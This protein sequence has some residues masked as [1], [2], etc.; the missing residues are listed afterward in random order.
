MSTTTSSLKPLEKCNF[1]DLFISNLPG[2]TPEDTSH[3]PSHLA[4]TS[5][6]VP[7]AC[8]SS[9][10]P[11]LVKAPKLLGWSEDMAHILGIEKPE[12]DSSSL[13]ALAGNSILPGMNPY[14]ARYGGHQFGHWAGQLGDGRAI[15]LGE[16]IIPE[17]GRWE[18]Q[19]KGAGP[20]PYSRRSDGRAVLRSSLREFLCSE[21]MHFLGIPTTRALSLVSTGDNVIRDMFYDGNPRPE[22]GAI[23]CRVSPSFIRFGNFEIHAHSNEHSILTKLA[24]F[25]IKEYFPDLLPHSKL[26]SPKLISL[27]KEL[28]KEIYAEWFKDVC[29]KTALMISHWMRVGFVHGVMNTDNMSILGLT[30]DYGPYGW[31]E[32]YDH[33][34]T[35]NTTDAQ[36]KR[37]AFANQVQIGLWNLARFGEALL[38]LVEEV[39]LLESGLKAYTETFKES[40]QSMLAKKL[41]LSN[42]SHEDDDLLISDLYELLHETETDMTLF[43][44]NLGGLIPFPKDK[45]NSTFQTNLECLEEAFYEKDILNSDYRAKL[46]AWLSRY[47]TRSKND[48]LSPEDKLITMNSANPHFILRNYLSHQASELAAEGDLSLLNRLLEALKRPYDPLPEHRDLLIRRPEWARNKAGCS[49]LSCSS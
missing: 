49:A 15:T 5:R 7:K 47:I 16:I 31:L 19:L 41:G 36:G 40:H 8:Y 3:E 28:P 33:S 21:A 34:W 27:D 43:F 12:A 30:I 38:P 44:R 37:Y 20:T 32:G 10:K 4:H 14:S 13:F 29:K 1:T 39:P 42:L 25:V 17:T 6:Q 11:S 2:E 46:E 35:P 9:V 23:T 22:P 18:I 45:P 48:E 24:N 26:N